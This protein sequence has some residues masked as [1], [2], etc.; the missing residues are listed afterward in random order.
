MPLHFCLCVMPVGHWGLWIFNVVLWNGWSDIE[1][2][3]GRFRWWENENDWCRQMAWSISLMR[4]QTWLLS[5]DWLGDFIDV[6]VS[7]VQCRWT[8]LGNFNGKLNTILT[9]ACLC[10]LF[11]APC[12]V[13]YDKTQTSTTFCWAKSV[14]MLATPN[15]KIP[16]ITKSPQTT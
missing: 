4:V 11:I 9:V 10:I 16:Q 12:Y 7:V 1:N 8:W 5:L 3:L 2:W 6:V 14:M 13:V 15:D